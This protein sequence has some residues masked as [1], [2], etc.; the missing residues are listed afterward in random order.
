MKAGPNSLVNSIVESLGLATTKRHVGDGALVGGPASLGELGL[1]N[2]LLL[3]SSISSPSDTT[4]DVGHG[5]TAVGA[6]DLDSD[7][8]GLLRD[9][10]LAGSDCASAVRT[11]TVAVLILIVVG[12]SLAPGRAA[13]ELDVVDVDT[14]VDHVDIDA[15][16]TFTIVHV[17]G[18]GGE[19]E[20]GPVADPGQ[21]LQ[22]AN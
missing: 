18:E 8:V 11:M 1:S 2:L 4:N 3:V 9:T 17:L 6:Q 12:N 10:V 20:L 21:T 15:L 16:T 7:E 22:E 5:A 14:G 19:S 13:L